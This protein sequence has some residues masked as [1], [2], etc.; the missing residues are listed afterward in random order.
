[1]GFWSGLAGKNNESSPVVS[2][3]CFFTAHSH[4]SLSQI[5]PIL[6]DKMPSTACLQRCRTDNGQ[7]YLN[8]IATVPLLDKNLSPIAYHSVGQ[9]HKTWCED[10]T[11][12][13]WWVSR[14]IYILWLHHVPYT[15][16]YIYVQFVWHVSAEKTHPNRSQSSSAISMA[17]R[18]WS[19]IYVSFEAT[20]TRSNIDED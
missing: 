19:V 4:T 5:M 17:L 7:I 1:M 10:G 18:W 12:F 2:C 9:K 16:I 13:L 3:G 6:M 8:N 14:L 11:S 20:K 15:Y